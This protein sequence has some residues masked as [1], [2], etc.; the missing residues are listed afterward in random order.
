MKSRISVLDSFRALAILAVLFYHYFSRWTFPKNKIS[1]YPYD[2]AYNY[3][4]YGHLGVEFFFIISGFV[5]FFTLENTSNFSVFWRKRVVRLVP[6]I[7]VAS[8]VTFTF[9]A[10][11]DSAGIFSDTNLLR[12]FIPSIL[13]ISPQIFNEIF[14]KGW[15]YI[16]GSYWSLWPEVQF[17]FLS[18]AL[19]FLNKKRF[20]TSYIITSSSLI[21]LNTVVKFLEQKNGFGLV[22]EVFFNSYELFFDKGFNLINYLPFFS[23]GWI[24]YIFYKKHQNQTAVNFLDKGYMGFLILYILF[25]TG[26]LDEPL[27]IRFIYF[28]M[29]ILFF[30][31][32]YYPQY[33]SFFENKYLIK[34][35]V[36]SY[37]L[38]LIHQ[39]I[40][41]L[42]IYNWGSISMGYILPLTII[43]ALI[44]I[45]IFYS[46]S[47]DRPFGK[48]LKNKL[49]K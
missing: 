20:L 47:L 40:G 24:F 11:F 3:F 8:I 48:W 12:N 35:G 25:I 6:P 13:F 7:I 39:N 21:C 19:Y 42:S 2:D 38:Y 33:L 44:P 41:V 1:L 37:F 26:G 30:T 10:L 14:G 36:S 43:I 27:I 22:P 34:I 29:I 15:A 32:I 4:E 46:E 5:I 23:L 17:Y 18:S 16:D 49:I 31:F 9:I 45:S 28:F